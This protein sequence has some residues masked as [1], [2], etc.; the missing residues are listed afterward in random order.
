MSLVVDSI[1]KRFGDVVALDDVS[2][3]VEPGRIFGLLGANGAGKTTSM[4]IVLDILRADSGD[5]TWKDT[6]NTDLPRKTWG[7]LPEERGLYARM[8][9]GEQLRFF[10]ALYGVPDADARAVIDDWLERFRIPEY[11]DRRVEELS[12]G[13]QQKIQFIAAIL[14]DPEVLIMDEPFSGLDPINVRLLKE[15]FLEMRDRGKTLIFSTHQMEQ[16]EELCESIAIVDRGRVVV[17]RRGP[18][19]QARHGTPGGPLRHRRRWAMA[20]RGSTGMP[21]VTLTAEREDFVEL[22]VPADHDPETILRTALDR[23]DRVTQ[24]RDRRAEPRGGLR[25]AR[26]ETRGQR[27]GGASRHNHHHRAGGTAVSDLFPN[28][29]HV[30]RREYLVRVRG[31]AFLITTALLALVVVGATLLPT[32]LGAFGVADPPEIAVSVEADDISGDAVASL[33]ALLTAANDPEGEGGSPVE[34]GPTVTRTEDPEAAAEDVRA[35]EL[36]GLLTITRAGDDELVFEYLSDQGPTSQTRVLVTQAANAIAVADRLD[37]AGVAPEETAAIFAPPDFTAIPVDP[38]A[39]EGED[40][41]GALLLAYIVVIL[42]F[43]AI[44]TYG[45]WVAQSVAEEKSGRVMELLITAATPRQLLTGKVLGTG[46]AGLTQYV[47]MIAAVLIGLVV[48]SPVSSILGVSGQVPFELPELE[49]GFLVAFT[50]FF[51]LGFLLYSTLY[52]AAGS[53]V[54][55]IEDVQQAV[56]PLIYLALAGYLISFIGLNDPDAD[57][58]ALAS[59]VPFFSPYLM[60]ARMLM[61]HPA[62]WEIVLAIVLL[63]VT[64]ALAIWLASRIY[65]AGVLLYGQRVGI[66]SSCGR[67][68]S[69]AD[70]RRRDRSSSNRRSS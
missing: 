49:A 3:S 8:K 11:L 20:S 38:D 44:L 64:L 58:I 25:R 40:F 45:N 54:S 27:G 48:A 56:G 41:A 66:R 67:P 12:K 17:Q 13:N 23:G 24:V 55:R 7:Y 47:V 51:L 34:E 29:L 4:R 18:R 19:R 28:A 30:A 60:P 43:M 9:V 15:A 36:D 5:V 68:A 10:A 37:R 42:T 57:W 69:R 62:P 21:G 35:G 39:L 26:R 2:F 59:L 70:V 61:G 14:H 31:K 53:M 1:T 22:R 52:A 6:A 65:S 16:V 46:A 32:I 50:G 63:A 33:Q